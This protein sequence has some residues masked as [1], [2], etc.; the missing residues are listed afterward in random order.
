MSDR[1]TGITSFLYFRPPEEM[2]A[3]REILERHFDRVEPFGAAFALFNKDPVL[4]VELHPDHWLMRCLA[5]LAPA[6]SAPLE[7]VMAWDAEPDWPR[8][9]IVQPAS[10]PFLPS[11][12][13]RER[14]PQEE[15]SLADG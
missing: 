1:H 3:I 2:A 14:V 5:D 4:W 10:P 12:G 13:G 9:F 8:S 15:R 11:D 7:I 6:L